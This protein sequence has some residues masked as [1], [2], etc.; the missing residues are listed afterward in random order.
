MEQPFH[1]MSSGDICMTE[2]ANNDHDLEVDQIGGLLQIDDAESSSI[3][4]EKGHVSLPGT[5]QSFI[6]NSS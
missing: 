4:I 3:N 6:G 2:Q 1:K 5:S